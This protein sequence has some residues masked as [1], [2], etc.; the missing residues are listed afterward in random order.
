M[1]WWLP[2][3][4]ADTYTAAPGMNLAMKS[5]PMRK[6][7]VPERHW[8]VATRAAASAGD[9]SPRSRRAVAVRNGA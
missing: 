6:E 2:H 8:M 9:A 3:V 1:L 5:A 7:P 4:G